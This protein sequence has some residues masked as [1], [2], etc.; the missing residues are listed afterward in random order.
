MLTFTQGGTSSTLTF[1][2]MDNPAAEGGVAVPVEGSPSITLSS[3][4]ADL[5]V[6][7]PDAGNPFSGVLEVDDDIGA[8]V[9]TGTLTATVDADLGPDVSNVV[10]VLAITIN[11][12]AAR[13][14]VIEIT[15]TDPA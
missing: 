4:I 14:T 11:P 9:L 5:L 1:T 10:G 15:A 3:E 7:T 13:A 2:P 6:Y 12:P 8:E